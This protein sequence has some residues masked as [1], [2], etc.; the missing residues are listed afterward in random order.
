MT[1]QEFISEVVKFVQKYA[2]QYGITVVSPIVAQ[3]VLESGWGET[4][5]AK[6]YHNYYGLKCGT[7]WTGP[8]VNMKTNEEYTEGVITVIKD[9]FRVFSSFEEGIKGYFDF[10]QLPRYENLKGITNP[11]DYLKIIKDDGYATDSKYVEK[12]M[13]IVNQYNLTQYDNFTTDTEKEAICMISNSGSDENKKYSGGKAGDQTGNEWN[14]IPWYNRPWNCVLRHPDAEVA[15][16]LAELAEEAAQNNNIGYDQGQ[17]TTFWARLSEVGYRPKNIKTPCEADCS[18]GVAA[19]V[20]AVGYLLKRVTLQNVSKDAYTG[21]LKAALKAAGFTVLTNTKYLT[22]GDYL[23]RGDILLNEGHHT[24]TNITTGP[25]ATPAVAPTTPSNPVEN[26]IGTQ[27]EVGQ[28]VEFI[29]NT[30]FTS[31]NARSGKPCTPGKAKVTQVYKM[32][33]AHP[34]HLVGLKG[35]GSNVYGWVTASDIKF[36]KDIPSSLIDDV[37]RGNYGNGEER[38]AAIIALGYDYEAVRKLVNARYGK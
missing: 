13:A 24:A 19:L 32:T 31:A 3:A 12:N 29:G 6:K 38:E 11:Y 7:R 25:K 28:E 16:L 14:I 37:I 20:K 22:S 2:P 21:N 1:K 33:S 18:A 4:F 34:Y 8:S 36:Q 35:G 26:P 17:R 5:L 10:I 23:V 15:N 27:F 9:N 30:H